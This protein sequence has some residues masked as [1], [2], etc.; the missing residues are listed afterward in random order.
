MEISLIYILDII[1]TFVFSLT[2]S[3]L[4][5][6]KRLDLFGIIIV[7]FVTAVGGGTVRD[8]LLGD[9][10]VF[11]FRDINYFVAASAGA[12]L[13]FCFARRIARI[14]GL[15][16]L[17]DALG[18]G[19]FTLIGL[20]KGLAYQLAPVFAVLMGVATAVAGGIIR[21]M[22][23]GEVPLV[24]RKEIYATACIAGGIVYLLLDMAGAGDAAATVAS[25]AVIVAIRLVS[26]RL[27]LSL[28]RRGD[29]GTE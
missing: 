7:G 18:I 27:K 15:L 4:G 21:D 29:M 12:V 10:P 17:F 9:T 25:I 23:C 2:G 28:P 13:T 22:L 26:L 11:W 24:L 14:N 16:M 6:R 5:V 1:G 3:I 19:V 8:L 20:K